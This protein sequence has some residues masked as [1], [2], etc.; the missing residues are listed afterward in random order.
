MF[1][2]PLSILL[3]LLYE[4]DE[5]VGSQD[6]FCE[7]KQ[8]LHP[9]LVQPLAKVMLSAQHYQDVSGTRVLQWQIH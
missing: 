5:I 6:L 4:L 2:I 3:V 7:F 1:F 9:N 8:V